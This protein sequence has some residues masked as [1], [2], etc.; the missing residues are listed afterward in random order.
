MLPSLNV[1]NQ[2]V[3]LL[4]GALSWDPLSRIRLRYTLVDDETGRPTSRFFT[5]YFE[6]LH[7]A[8][9]WIKELDV[10]QGTTRSRAAIAGVLHEWTT[11][12]IR[13]V[14]RFVLC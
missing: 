5:Y 2:D 12:G 4:R 7:A 14:A 11:T 3:L 1:S 9:E 6:T 13:Y 10:L 8:E